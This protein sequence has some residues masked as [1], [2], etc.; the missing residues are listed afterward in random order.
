MNIQGC[1]PLGLLVWSPCCLRDSQESSPAPQSINSLETLGGGE[2]HLA[3]LRQPSSGALVSGVPKDSIPSRHTVPVPWCGGSWWHQLPLSD[4]PSLTLSSVCLSVCLSA[5]GLVHLCLPHPSALHLEE[6]GESIDRS[7]ELCSLQS[8]Q[9]KC[10]DV[11]EAGS[12]SSSFKFSLLIFKYMSRPDVFLTSVNNSKVDEKLK[13]VLPAIIS[14]PLSP[15]RYQH[16]LAIGLFFVL[17][18]TTKIGSYP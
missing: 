12:F 4:P 14:K 11:S 16:I 5:F 17:F 7:H 6:K 13:S 8:N 1:F 9:V 2:N 3:P 18:L 10:I 15:C